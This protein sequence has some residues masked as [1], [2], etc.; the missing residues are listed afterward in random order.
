MNAGIPPLAAT[1]S[2]DDV[3]ARLGDPA[4]LLT[5][6]ELGRAQRLRSS[7]DRSDFMAA[8]GLVRLVAG[9]LLDCGPDDLT[10]VQRCARCGGPHGQPYIAEQPA[11]QVSWSHTRGYV[12]AIAGF[13][14]VAVDVEHPPPVPVD[15][16]LLR[17]VLSPSEQ[18][19][20]AAAPDPS[21]AFA[22]HWVRKES[23][24]KLG[25]ATLDTMATT[26]LDGLAVDSS[27]LAIGGHRRLTWRGW[28]LVEWSDAASATVG[29]AMAAIPTSLIRIGAT[30]PD[31][32][33]A[34][35][36]LPT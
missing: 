20:V 18:S 35:G 25:M 14:P 15:G 22:R 34:I 4:A 33:V 21:R 1:G 26:E 19:V 13:V 10:V 8:H 28:Y 32:L 17:L 5:D 7:S 11:L 24:V 29:T 16:A 23:L 2:T 27:W 30:S 12:A 9:Q 31:R 6:V 3:A 36:Q